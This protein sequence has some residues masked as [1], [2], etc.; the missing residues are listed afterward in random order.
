[1]SDPTNI[2]LFPGVQKVEPVP[3]P[4]PDD[5]DARQVASTLVTAQNTIK[6][7]MIV[8]GY[9]EEGEFTLLASDMTDERILYL[10]GLAMHMVYEGPQIQDI[11]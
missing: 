6:Q 1:M 9:D 4:D 10:L 5:L 3:E 11:E 7:D 2:L 8:L